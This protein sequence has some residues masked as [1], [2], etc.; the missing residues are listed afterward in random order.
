MSQRK[1]AEEIGIPRK[2]VG[3]SLEKTGGRKNPTDK[4]A[5]SESPTETSSI[6]GH[7]ADLIIID[8][9]GVEE[10]VTCILLIF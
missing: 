10:D 2:T 1:I 3:D 5:H 9:I 6:Q 4:T 7:K 8:E